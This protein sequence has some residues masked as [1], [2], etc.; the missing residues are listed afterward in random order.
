MFCNFSET[1]T[2][3]DAVVVRQAIEAI[4]NANEKYKKYMNH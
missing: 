1:F 3:V 4:N 2:A